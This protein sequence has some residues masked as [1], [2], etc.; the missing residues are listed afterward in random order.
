MRKI[1]ILFLYTFLFSNTQY[2]DNLFFL[3]NTI[4]DINNLSSQD[5]VQIET[6]PSIY[7]NN[8]I[9]A[10]L[11]SAILPGSAQYLINNQKTKGIIFS[12][13]EILGWASYM[14]YTNQ[15]EMF[16]IDYQ[17]YAD[18]HWSFSNWCDHY[19]DYENSDNPFRDL[20]SNEDSGEYSAINSG[21]GL[22]FFYDDPNSEPIDGAERIYAKTNTSAFQTLYEAEG[23][24][25]DGNAEEFVN[26][27]NLS[28]LRTH[29]FYEEIVKY[30]QFFTGWDDQEQIERSTND[31]GQD[32]ATS[33]NKTYAKNIYDKSVRNYKIQD[34]AM[35][36]IYAN[37]AISMID[38]LIVSSLS[39]G[40]ASLS[41]DYN[42]TIDFHQAEIII[43][44]N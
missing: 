29:N 25:I 12:A 33:P 2:Y 27:Y 18:E 15:A 3:S 40:N 36:A 14:Y 44:L 13:I 39:S 17:N 11:F 4:N 19:Y 24:D 10:V 20:F 37:H 31:W 35:I 5:S 22:E 9:K 16:K 41:Y 43:K 32:N 7:N 28:I 21:H 30:D 38:A 23:L 34:W 42:P 6:V 1:I 26:Q 8:K